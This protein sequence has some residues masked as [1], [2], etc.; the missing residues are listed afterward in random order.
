MQ[1]LA[2]FC[3]SLPLAA[4]ARVPQILWGRCSHTVE[5]GGQGCSEADAPPWRCVLQFPAV[6]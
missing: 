2:G 4:P 3:Q 5:T 1:L 6:F